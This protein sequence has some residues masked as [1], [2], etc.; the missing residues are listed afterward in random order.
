MRGA[1]HP[2]RVTGGSRGRLPGASRW[3]LWTRR[4]RG[5]ARVESIGEPSSAPT[6]RLRTRRG[7]PHLIPAQPPWQV[8]FRGPEKPVVNAERGRLGC[9][10]GTK[11]DHKP[12]YGPDPRRADRTLN[13][14]HPRGESP[15][16]S[17]LGRPLPGRDAC[18]DPG[19]QAKHRPVSHGLHVPTLDERARTMEITV[20][21][22]QSETITRGP[23]DRAR[24][25][26]FGRW[27]VL[28]NPR[29]GRAP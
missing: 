10:D 11:E 21:D 24:S 12:Q 26:W 23:W 15:P 14:S 19:R 1:R 9:R 22:V 20:C 2:P 3:G 5:L 6:A 28:L 17:R 13:P 18:A 25:S 4:S 8:R 7:P 16:G 29:D 27:V